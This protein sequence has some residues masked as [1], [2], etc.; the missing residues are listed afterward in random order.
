MK[1][2]SA[3]VLSVLISVFMMFG[4]SGDDTGAYIPKPRAYHRIELPVHEYRA[5]ADSSDRPFKFEYSKHATILPDTSFMSEKHWLEMEYEPHTVGSIHFTYKPI[6]NNRKLF[7]DY[8]NDAQTLAS[9]HNVKAYAIEQQYVKHKKG[10]GTVFFELEGD[11]PT[12]FHYYITD[13]TEHFF[14]AAMYV[15]TSQKNDSLAPV[16]EYLREDMMHILET[17]EFRNSEAE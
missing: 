13:S 7:E 4:C 2:K 17:F 15:P 9:K 16:L 1:Y 3:L 8:V 12:T 14:R 6:Q 11:V 5:F 10:Y